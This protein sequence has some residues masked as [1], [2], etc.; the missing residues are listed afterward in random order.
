M[1]QYCCCMGYGPQEP[2]TKSQLLVAYWFVEPGTTPGRS[3]K[4]PEHL[5]FSQEQTK[6]YPNHGLGLTVQMYP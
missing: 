2:N 4:D 3:F 1:G 6:I 5:C